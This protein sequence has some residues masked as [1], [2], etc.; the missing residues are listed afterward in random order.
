MVKAVGNWIA[1]IIW[2]QAQ[3]NCHNIKQ[4]HTIFIWEILAE[5]DELKLFNVIKNHF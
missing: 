1:H 2:P 3:D 4:R 5:A